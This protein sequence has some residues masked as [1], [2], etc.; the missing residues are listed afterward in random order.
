MSAAA[1]AK[2]ADR[3]RNE[4][5][6]FSNRGNAR[7]QVF[8][9]VAAEEVTIVGKADKVVDQAIVRY[10]CKYFALADAHT[11]AYAE[12]SDTD[13]RER[14]FMFGLALLKWAYGANSY[15]DID[16]L[17]VRAQ[18]EVLAAGMVA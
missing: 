2:I 3:D 15:N 6:M 10:F 11:E 9:D 13:V 18:E 17:W 16:A 14:V 5:G 8:A 1:F 12:A 4:W 7:L